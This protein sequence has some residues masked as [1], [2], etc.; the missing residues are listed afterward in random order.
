MSA[1]TSPGGTEGSRV[2]ETG[3]LAESFPA[4]A[5]IPQHV[6]TEGPYSTPAVLTGPYS[7]PAVLTATV[8]LTNMDAFVTSCTWHDRVYR[9]ALRQRTSVAAAHM[10]R[11]SRRRGWPLNATFAFWHATS[12]LCILH[13]CWSQAM[14]TIE[15]HAV[16]FLRPEAVLI[17]SSECAVG[18]APTTAL[19][20]DGP[21]MRQEELTHADQKDSIPSEATLWPSDTRVLVKAWLHAEDV[22]AICI[23]GRL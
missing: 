8:Q 15:D 19:C 18:A 6:R 23:Q 5:T 22:S 7:T 17:V 16:R 14:G 13:P 1:R 10:R 11:G 9:R 3:K 4:R 2:Y 20:A 12:F 21:S